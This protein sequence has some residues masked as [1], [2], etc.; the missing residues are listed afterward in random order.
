MNERQAK[1]EK[2]R[3]FFDDIWRKGDF[4]Q[5]ETSEFE[6]EK[7]A[8]QLNFLED[9]RYGR[10]L[11]IGCGSGCF[12]RLIA[13]IADEV[14]AL[15]VSSRAIERARSVGGANGITFDVANIME[16]DPVAAGPWDLIV[17][18]ET[19]Y[20]LGWLYSVFDVAWLAMCLF[21]ATRG[22]GRLLMCNTESGE[23]GEGYLLLPP[24]IRTYRDLMLNVGYRLVAE[25]RFRGSKNGHEIEAL[26]S[27]FTKR[28]PLIVD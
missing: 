5:L 19:V 2:T 1:H 24:I 11:E 26:V 22:G 17:M 9:R 16:Y 10:V 27:C 18:S 7:Y 23:S 25:D 8:Y 20:Y 3:A 13:S 15:D 21:E 6:R 28:E 4:W 14:V 12:S